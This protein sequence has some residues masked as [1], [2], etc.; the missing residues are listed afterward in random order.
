MVGGMKIYKVPVTGDHR[1]RFSLA[2][3][4]VVPSVADLYV[5]PFPILTESF[6]KRS[7]LRRRAS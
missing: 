1:I 3:Q 7:W 5:A 2:R 6:Y 4:P